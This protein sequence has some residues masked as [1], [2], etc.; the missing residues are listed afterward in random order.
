MRRPLLRIKG[1]ISGLY[2]SRR[3]RI[4]PLGYCFGPASAARRMRA[5]RVAR[6]IRL[7]HRAER[8]EG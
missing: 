7:T 8:A 4:E 3:V 1:Q 2:P 6:T 5:A